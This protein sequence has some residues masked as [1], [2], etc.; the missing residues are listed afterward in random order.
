MPPPGHHA[1]A[2]LPKQG[3]RSPEPPQSV[4]SSRAWSGRSSGAATFRYQWQR[5]NSN[6]RAC[7]PTGVA[8]RGRGDEHA[9]HPS[10]RRA[11]VTG[12]EFIARTAQ[13]RDIIDVEADAGDQNCAGYRSSD[14]CARFVGAYFAGPESHRICHGVRRLRQHPAR[15]PGHLKPRATS[16]SRWCGSLLGPDHGRGRPLDHQRTGHSSTGPGNQVLLPE[17]AA[18]CHRGGHVWRRTDP[19]ERSVP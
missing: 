3:R 2:R 16:G 15:E 13:G 19:A 6:G 11:Q 18:L 1:I 8:R 7:K 17:P 10:R 9:A 12:R 14:P 4:T 5:C